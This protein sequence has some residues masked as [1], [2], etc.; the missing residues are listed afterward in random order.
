MVLQR[1]SEICIYGIGYGDGTVTLGNETKD[2]ASKTGY[3]KVYFSP[4]EASL[5]PV[6]FTAELSGEKIS[7]SNVLIGDVYV[8]SGQ[9]NMELSIADTEHKV[10]GDF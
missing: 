4:L 7:F 5:T 10:N 2:I 9:S 3:W 1:G 8:S 6:K